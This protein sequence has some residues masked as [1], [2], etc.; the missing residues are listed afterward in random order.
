[1]AIMG[2]FL[3]IFA[4]ITGNLQIF[5]VMSETSLAE[6]I[7]FLFLGETFLVMTILALIIGV[8]YLANNSAII[9]NTGRFIQAI[10]ALFFTF[11]IYIY[12]YYY[13]ESIL[14]WHVVIVVIICL[15][16]LFI[17]LLMAIGKSTNSRK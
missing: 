2:I 14:K 5:Q 1:M 8:G 16:S 17:I 13:R 4:L 12:C 15:I 3:A 6:T 7:M 9:K 10:V 11:P